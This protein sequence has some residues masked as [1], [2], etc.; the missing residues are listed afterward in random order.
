[1]SI[2]YLLGLLV[3]CRELRGH[4]IMLTQVEL[5]H[6]ARE[7]G[8]SPKALSR[9]LGSMSIQSKA[10]YLEMGSEPLNK[11]IHSQYDIGLK[12]QK[13][14]SSLLRDRAKYVS[15]VRATVLG[16]RSAC[17]QVVNWLVSGAFNPQSP[18]D[19]IGRAQLTHAARTAGRL[20]AECIRRIRNS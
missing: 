12:L 13:L 20:K 16:Y 15:A 2:D 14:D 19:T 3:M 7:L 10:Q 4:L 9:L 18:P 11:V 5:K 6:A 8:I 17:P 1:M